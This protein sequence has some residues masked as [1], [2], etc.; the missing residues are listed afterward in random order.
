MSQSN[1][2]TWLQFA[3]QQMA[4]ES[5]LDQLA[6]GRQ[7]KDILKD[8]NND[9]RVIPSEQ[10]SGKTRFTDQLTSYFVP[11][12]GS[13][14]RYQIVDHHANDATG[15][16]AT[17]LFDT[18]TQTHTLSFRSTEFLQQVDGGDRER[19]GF[20][21]DLEISSDGFAFGQLVA[22]ED[23][24]QSLKASGKL[25][26]GAVLNVTGYSLGG[27]LATI[28]TELHTNEVNHAYTFNG[29]GRGHITGT[30]ATEVERMQ[31]MLDLLRQVL[32]NPDAGLPHVADAGNNSRYLAAVSLAGQPFSPFTSET[33]LGGAGTSTP[34]RGIA[35]QSKWRPRPTT[36]ME[37]V[38]FPARWEPVPHSPRSRS[39]MGWPRPEI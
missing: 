30:G 7:L 16:S 28:F 34:M 25:P 14:P 33:T 3:L 39:S 6:S 1:I 12:P 23:Y 15:F 19:D 13:S 27:H 38:V 9:I 35:G 10:F 37:S 20:G 31:G 29:A 5:Y 11:A 2:S 8:G 18:Q 36:P 4:A 32:F 22:M 24:Y 26:A 17:L 21:A